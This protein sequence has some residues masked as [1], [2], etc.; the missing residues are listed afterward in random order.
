MKE[1]G[2]ILFLILL[3]IILF[4]ALSYAVMGGFRVNQDQNLPKE[5]ANALAAEIVQKTT[6]VEQTVTRL[7][8]VG[9]CKD[10]EIQFTVSGIIAYDTVAPADNHCHVFYKAGGGLNNP[11]FSPEM[12]DSVHSAASRYGTSIMTSNLVTNLGTDCTNPYLEC[13]DLMMIVPFLKKDVCTA[14]NKGYGVTGIPQ[15]AGNVQLNKFSD[16]QNTDNGTPNVGKVIGGT[17]I[18]GRN[19]LC[20][21]GKN[22]VYGISGT[23]P[24][25]GQAYNSTSG[26]GT[27]VYFYY[28]TLIA[29]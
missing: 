3:A 20:F 14:I 11:T 6:L 29:R 28:H 1:R 22:A 5:K 27:G 25:N 17:D 18:N 10:T 4:V 12:F 13:A 8:V 2:N 16:Y 9:D 19:A 7:R 21:E 15:I 24:L 26:G 23:N